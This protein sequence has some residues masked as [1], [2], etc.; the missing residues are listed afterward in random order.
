[1]LIDSHVHLDGQQFDG[2]RA[3]VIARARAAGVGMM[4]EIAGSDIGGGSLQPG[5]QLAES[6][7]FIFA[8]VGLHPHEASLFDSEL[9]KLLLNA[10][11]HPKVVGWGEI[12]LD[13]HYDHSPRSIQREVFRRQLELAR[14]QRLPVIIH[15][16]EA[17]SDT[18]EILSAGW[19]DSTAREIGGVFHCFSG[20]PHLAQSAL[21]MGFHLS[22]SGVVTFR[23]AEEL[24]E[25]AAS[26]PLDRL[27]VETD[28]PYLAPVPFRGKRNEPAFVRETASLIASLRGLDLIEFAQATS[29]NFGRLFRLPIPPAIGIDN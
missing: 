1:M 11:A 15:T 22:F 24:R 28:C 10:A 7:D 6:Y 26:A 17:E 13:Y 16:R 5:L 2:D 18:I 27:L 3:D 14:A 25:I 4:L 9:E 21:E 23:T 19:S 8:A 29:A 20:S 12:G